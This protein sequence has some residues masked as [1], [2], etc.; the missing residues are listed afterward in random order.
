MDDLVTDIKQTEDLIGDDP[1][2]NKKIS[3]TPLYENIDLFYQ[4]TV[5]E[6]DAFPL[7]MPT[8]VLEPPKEKPPPP[9]TDDNVEDELLGNVSILRGSFLEQLK[10]STKTR[11]L[12]GHNIMYLWKRIRSSHVFKD[13][14][15]KKFIKVIMI[16]H[17]LIKYHKI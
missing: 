12:N 11:Y 13:I 17:T 8:N 1:E 16:G 3:V 15:S 5:D 6:S 14:P 10:L 9:P 4:N 2:F 7:D